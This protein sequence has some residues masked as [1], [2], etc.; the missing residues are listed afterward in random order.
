MSVNYTSTPAGSFGT[1]S[2]PYSSSTYT[3]A[4]NVHSFKI[5][6]TVVFVTG[7]SLVLVNNIDNGKIPEIWKLLYDG[8]AI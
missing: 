6:V 4:G 5:P 1:V 8:K 7:M 2:T 3:P